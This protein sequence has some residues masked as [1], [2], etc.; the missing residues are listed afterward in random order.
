MELINLNFEGK[1]VSLI[2]EGDGYI[3]ATQLCKNAGREFHTWHRS[4]STIEFLEALSAE[5][6]FCGTE[7][8]Q[9][10][11]GGDP[12]SQ[13]TWIHPQVAINL[14]QWLSP[15]FAVAVSKWVQD[16]MSGKYAN[17]ITKQPTA[18]SRMDILK[19]AIQAEEENQKLKV[20]LQEKDE[21]VQ[22]YE[23]MLKTDNLMKIKDAF[24]ILKIW[25]RKGFATLRAKKILMKTT[26]ATRATSKY[27]KKKYFKDVMLD[28]K[29]TDG[30]KEITYNSKL[31]PLGFLWLVEKRNDIFSSDCFKEDFYISEQTKKEMSKLLREATKQDQQFFALEQFSGGG[32]N[33]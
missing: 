14:G 33:V 13:G 22:K 7:I 32:L 5:P 18:L 2:R 16:W 25:E 15:K 29:R 20:E 8:I 26:Q 23:S 19:L 6:Q 17:P 10:K 3:N 9:I 28:Y 12:K 31:T 24:H 1:P 27:I 30:T 21:L 4:Q 11:K